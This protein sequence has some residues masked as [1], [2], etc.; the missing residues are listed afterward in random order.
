MVH[1]TDY[2]VSEVAGL[3]S[4]ISTKKAEPIWGI[5]DE[6]ELEFEGFFFSFRFERNVRISDEEKEI[7]YSTSNKDDFYPNVTLTHKPTRNL[8]ALC[9][10]TQKGRLYLTS[11]RNS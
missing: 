7:S 2:Q 3:D 8:F 6:K 4:V 9:K 11:R 5:Q 10:W 1:R